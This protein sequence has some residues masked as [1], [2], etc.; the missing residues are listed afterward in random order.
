MSEA[1]GKDVVKAEEAIVLEEFAILRYGDYE[2][3]DCQW[4]P[5]DDK[6]SDDQGKSVCHA[7]FS[8]FRDTRIDS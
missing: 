8:R 2:K 7:H 6:A 1:N 4:R 5:A 3:I